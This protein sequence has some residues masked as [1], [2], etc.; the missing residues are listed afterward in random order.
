MLIVPGL[1]ST[2]G[3]STSKSLPIPPTP[4]ADDDLHPYPHRGDPNGANELLAVV[5]MHAILDDTLHQIRE[6]LR[7]TFKTGVTR[8]LAWRKHQLYQLARLVQNEADALCD[9]LAKD[10]SKPR[11]EVLMTE[12]GAIVE[13]ATK[14]A[15]QLDAWAMP[16]HPEVPDWQKGWKPTVF[17]APKGTV[18]IISPWNYPVILTFQP[19]IGAIA[20]GCCAVLKPSEAVPH[21]SQLFAD[22]LPKY[23]DPSAY[24]VVNGAVQEATKLLELQWDHIFY[25]GNSRVARIVA[26]AAAKYLTPLSLELGGKSPVLVDS[27]YDMDLAAKR[28]LWG[29]CNNA[30]QICVAPDYILVP[31]TKQDELVQG[32][33]KAYKSFF[34]D[35]ALGDSHYGSIVNKMHF[36]RLSSLLDRTKGEKIT[37]VIQGRK[38]AARKRI[39][40][41]VVT[42][43][44]DGDALMEE[45][46]FGPILPIIPVDTLDE[47][48]AIINARPH[49]LVLYAFTEDAIVKQKRWLFSSPVCVFRLTRHFIVIKET[50]SGGIV[51]NDT[52]QQLA[53]NELPFAGVGESGYGYQ[54]MKYTYDTFTQLRGSIDMPK[55]AESFL[56]LRYP[57]HGPDAVKALTGAVHLPIPRST[58]NDR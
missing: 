45:E 24:R 26:S 21:V 49:P 14:S 35:G 38:D 37:D 43:V 17:K 40:P 8:P 25:T 15:E 2:G 55:E 16:E 29:K 51:F 39:E 44:K 47:A 54:I 18:L 36:D 32:F 34:P 58:P 50:Q 42:H 13:R 46:L 52:F 20:A 7:A 19:L 1:L 22:L 4:V 9:A 57:P 11:V 3:I 53:V 56:Q 33:K 10:L 12:I 5:S 23:L 27:A 48:L 41:T 30:G 31:W 28:I 6:T